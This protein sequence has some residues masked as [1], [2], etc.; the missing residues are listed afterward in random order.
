MLIIQ[1]GAGDI[2]FASV[3]IC[4]HLPSSSKLISELE[5]RRRRLEMDTGDALV[6]ITG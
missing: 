5:G 1:E 6:H 2:E 3:K 4:G